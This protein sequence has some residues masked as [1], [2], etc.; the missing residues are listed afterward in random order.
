MGIFEKYSLY[1]CNFIKTLSLFVFLLTAGFFDVLLSIVNAF[2]DLSEETSVLLEM[3][4]ICLYPPIHITLTFSL[5]DL[6][7]ALLKKKDES[8]DKKA[9]VDNAEFSKSEDNSIDFFRSNLDG[10]ILKSAL[11]SN[12]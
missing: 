12:P 7:L 2:I 6:F 3:I 9:K 11:D 1:Y 8:N 5:L 10:E 4:T